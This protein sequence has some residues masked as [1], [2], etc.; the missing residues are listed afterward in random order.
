MAKTKRE[1]TNTNAVLFVSFWF[2]LLVECAALFTRHY[3]IYTIARVL[4]IPIL[5]TRVLWSANRYKMNVYFYLCLLLSFVAD[6]FTLFGNQNISY[7]G[8]SLYSVSYLAMAS[9]FQEIKYR[10]TFN[11]I[12]FLITSTI[13]GVLVFLWLFVSELHKQI[14]YIQIA[15]HCIILFYACFSFYVIRKEKK[16][17]SVNLFMLSL[18]FVL[19]SNL[20]FALDI[21]YFHR[22]L[23]IMDSL[24]GLG[25]GLYLYLFT[26]GTLNEAKGGG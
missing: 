9:Y 18:S 13:I 17:F 11:H 5:L 26:K 6:L 12:I 15:L 20:V 8:L 14:F 19:F 22:R 24:V 21:L 3:T 7:I 10:N 2:F 4:V 23:S 16:N 25:N 1:N